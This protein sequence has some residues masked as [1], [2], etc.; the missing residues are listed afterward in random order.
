MLIWEKF[1][2]LHRIVRN[3]DDPNW[4]II[5]HLQ[6]NEGATIKDLR[7]L[8]GVTTTAVRRYILALQAEGYVERRRVTTGVGR[9]HH[10]YY[11]TTK[12]NELF[13][14]HCD[15]LALTLLEEVFAV[16]G[17]EHTAML[18]DRVST[19]LAQNYSSGMR[20]SVLQNRVEEFATV[21]HDR[22]ILSDVIP[23][24]DDSIILQTYNCPYH[25]LAQ[26]YREICEMDQS[27]MQKAL[28]SNVDLTAC[29]ADGDGRCSFTVTSRE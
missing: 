10:V 18:L 15:E 25:E 8:L 2:S 21:L 13:A 5:E 24:D 19:R 1:M 20:S 23:Q 11:I 22:G 26:E 27:V 12:A 14:C 17:E 7:E 3:H 16:E 6:R 9:P 29:M 28:G 4:M